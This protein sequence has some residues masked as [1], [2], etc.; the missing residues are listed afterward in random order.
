MLSTKIGIAAGAALVVAFA[1]W[2]DSG[3][4][5][6]ARVIDGDTLQIG[7]TR[8]RLWGIDAFEKR[9]MCGASHCGIAAMQRMIELTRGETI[10]CTREATDRYGRTVARC[11]ANNKDLGGQL[12]LEGWALDYT[13]YSHGYYKQHEYSAKASSAGAWSETFEV[14]WVWRRR[15]G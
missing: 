10:S 9:Q 11:Y 8:V 3:L 15:A 12:V 5:G 4:S 2:A 1:S 13:Q 14:P 7:Q 6:P